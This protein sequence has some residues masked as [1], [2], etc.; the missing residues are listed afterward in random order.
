MLCGDTMQRS[1]LGIDIQGV[2]ALD[3]DVLNGV[4]HRAGNA[5]QHHVDVVTLDQLA[6]V[7]DRHRLVGSGILNM[8]LD[9]TAQEPAAVVDLVHHHSGD[10]S[11]R[12]TGNADGTSEVCGDA[13]FD[14]PS[15]T[16]PVWSHH[17]TAGTE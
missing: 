14:R 10:V 11:I 13:H 1:Q 7:A 4:A 9:L 8:Q 6:D 15:R 2:A 5:A 3:N 16:G 12:L 17:H